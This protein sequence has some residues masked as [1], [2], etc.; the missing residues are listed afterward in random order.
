LSFLKKRYF[1]LTEVEREV[2]EILN[3]LKPGSAEKMFLKH[4]HV[5]KKPVSTNL[6][7]YFGSCNRMKL[8]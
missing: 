5:G 2:E 3:H 4:M 8:A 7:S 6:T 1:L